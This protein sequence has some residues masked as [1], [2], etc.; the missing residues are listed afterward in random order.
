MSN[1][2][3]LVCRPTPDITAS[4]LQRPVAGKLI[5]EYLSELPLSEHYLPAVCLDGVPVDPWRFDMIRVDTGQ[6]LTVAATP[7]DG[8]SGGKDIFIMIATIALVIAAPYAGAY[9]ASAIGF[10]AFSSGFAIAAGIASAAVG[11]V[12]TIAL[13][14][15]AP[16]PAS[17]LSELSG[18]S[19]STSPSYSISGI[20][21]QA[22]PYSPVLKVFGKHRVFPPLVA[23]P[24]TRLLSGKQYLYM[25]FG[26]YGNITIES[27]KIGKTPIDDFEEVIYWFDDTA[28]AAAPDN[29]LFGKTH[30]QEAINAQLNPAQP[31]PLRQNFLTA[32]DWIQRT[33]ANAVTEL[34]EL[35]FEMPN[36]VVAVLSTGVDRGWQVDIEIQVKASSS[37]TWLAVDSNTKL[38]TALTQDGDAVSY[39]DADIDDEIDYYGDYDGYNNAA[40]TTY[41]TAVNGTATFSL[42]GAKLGTSKRKQISIHMSAADEYDVRVR[43]LNSKIRTTIKNYKISVSRVV[44]TIYWTSLESISNE[45]PVQL[46]DMATF[47]LKV[48]ATNQFH[49]I[50][51]QL[52]FLVKSEALD[53]NGAAWVDGFTQNPAS[54]FRDALQGNAA[55]AGDSAEA[56][57]TIPD[58]RIDLTALQEWHDH[59]ASKGYKFNAIV[60]SFTS[61]EAILFSICTAGRA[62]PTIRDGKFSVIADKA[63]TVPRQFITSLN[64][65]GYTGKYMFPD[66]PHAFRC[67]FPDED[68]DYIQTERI[69]YDDGYNSSTATKFEVLD[70]YGITDSDNV[71]KYARYLLAVAHLRPELHTVNMDFEHLVATRGDLVRFAHDVISTGLARGRVKNVLLDSAGL[72]IGIVLDRTVTVEAGKEYGIVARKTDGTEY[73]VEVRAAAGTDYF[74]ADN[75]ASKNNEANSVGS[76]S[77]NASALVTVD[78]VG[79]DIGSKYSAEADFNTT[80]A[81]DNNIS[82]DLI[83][84]L[85]LSG[86]EDLFLS[87][88]VRHVST[89]G[90][91][92]AVLSDR[93]ALNT[94]TTNVSEDLTS[95]NTTFKYYGLRFT[96]AAAT[97][98]YFGTRE[99]SGTNDGGTFLDHVSLYIVDTAGDTDV[100]FWDTAITAST[101]PEVGDLIMFGELGSETR[102][103]LI[104]SIDIHPDLSAT[105]TLS[106]YN[107]AI[108]NVD[109]ESIPAFDPGITVPPENNPPVPSA[110]AI[111]KIQSDEDVLQVAGGSLINTIKIIFGEPGGD[112][113]SARGLDLVVQIREAGETD[114]YDNVFVGDQG[115]GVIFIDNNIKS[116]TAYDIRAAYDSRD[117]PGIRSVWT[118]T[119]HTAIGKSTLPPDVSSFY[120]DGNLLTW[121]YPSPPADVTF[122]GGFQI[123][124][125]H[126]NNRDW[127][128]A[129]P[130]HKDTLV[131]QPFSLPVIG[132]EKT[133]LI[134]AIDSE[135]NASSAPAI[136][137]YDFGDA[138]LN[139]VVETVDYDALSYPGINARASVFDTRS[140]N[141]ISAP[142][143]AAY[144]ISFP[145]IQ[146]LLSFDD[147]TPAAITYIA[148]IYET[149]GNQLSWLIFLNTDGTL[150]FRYSTDGSTSTD[151]TSTVVPDITA[152]EN[153]WL[154]IVFIGD[155]DASQHQVTFSISRNGRETWE[156]IGTTTPIA[157]TKTLFTS[158]ATL[159]VGNADTGSSSEH[160]GRVY[161]FELRDDRSQELLASLN[162]ND[163]ESTSD[164]AWLSAPTG[165]TWTIGGSVT[166]SDE[167][168][169][170]GALASGDLKADDT[171]GAWWSGDAA[172]FWSTD[173]TDPF[174]TSIYHEMIYEFEY[175]V[176]PSDVDGMIII[177]ETVTAS[178]Y[179]IEYRPDSIDPFWS[180]EST[181]AF[182]SSD[183]DPFWDGSY[184][185][186]TPFVGC[187][188][189]LVPHTYRF[190]ITTESNVTRG[191]ISDL[192]LTLD[193]SDIGEEIQDQAVA[194]TGTTISLTK[195]YRDIKW[196]TYTIQDDGGDAVV[197]RYSTDPANNEITI[198]AYDAAN[199]LTTA[200][201][202]LKI[203]G[204]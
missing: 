132:K 98:D 151:L 124:Y 32:G 42:G 197:V 178:G 182:W 84:D 179:K 107:A 105:L 173:S 7:A 191:I 139:N 51:D 12:G 126:G 111:V 58:S 81:A 171:N 53:W 106:D 110:P 60:D 169:T 145:D 46:E 101:A 142:H 39:S 21:N 112:F 199:A 75:A 45:D 27:V 77:V 127:D 20:R 28:G 133:I 16:S 71:F 79:I 24:Y 125:Q 118:T 61:T 154:K 2:I 34:L 62:F 4:T 13:Q 57:F 146:I 157:G 156:E 120:I 14:A 43:L 93:A 59:C 152:G 73:T 187:L 184:Q 5:S 1:D 123:R 203:G 109:S 8:D 119:T 201:L 23:A 26:L 186:F 80:P 76:W 54:H 153:V 167:G 190:R 89:G 185:E 11:I 140:G 114:P 87:F 113:H 25:L 163:S 67:R 88:G 128:S 122:G 100:L 160:N 165:E 180:A 66:M 47:G 183:S 70:L 95:S 172:A 108:Y 64:S 22:R 117:Y 159:E 135:G 141:V 130:L 136:I 30:A 92:R 102:D 143:V 129:I 149:T 82:I 44:D 83:N 96:L 115:N 103:C 3:K 150:V 9:I 50:I 48:K 144:D 17:S 94:V 37:G 170:N 35:E 74:D 155:D 55:S 10:S 181:D 134:K 202:D 78:E 188:N 195:E 148:G 69:V 166:L 15:L 168:V 90:N 204:Y 36:G 63:Q 56:T 38:V 193:A 116:A 19:T 131:N 31:D 65:W 147:A 137:F 29:T 138:V 198:K 161:R 121:D 196:L 40:P 194:I 175:Q 158:T 174:W 41:P 49:G 18:V 72:A 164:S 189:T 97:N 176:Q 85:G 91:V 33:T 104:N 86:G 177:D 6:E 162:I 99:N 52:N 200:N 68:N 192:T